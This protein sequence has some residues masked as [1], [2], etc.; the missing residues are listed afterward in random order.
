M[1][2][3]RPGAAQLISQIIANPETQL[4]ATDRYFR[5]L[6]YHAPEARTA[7]LRH[8]ITKLDGTSSGALP[9]SAREDAIIVR[10]VERID[11]FDLDADPVASAAVRRQLKRTHGTVA[12]FDLVKRFRPAGIQQSLLELLASDVDDST[13]VEAV[14]M[15]AETEDGL[16]ILKREL[17]SDSARSA[18]GIARVLGLWGNRRAINMLSDTASVAERSFDVRKEA[19]VG[20]AC[21]RPGQLRLISLAKDGRLPADSQLLAGGLLGQS[22][23]ESIRNEA[24]KCLPSITQKDSKPLAPIDKLSSM[25]GSVDNGVAIFRGVGTCANC[26]IVN[27]F[28]K[29]VGPDL[30]E[31][32][33]KLSREAMYTSILAP[34]AGISHNYETYSLLTTGGQVFS[35]LLISETPDEVTIRTVDAIDR[36][37][38]QG[39]IEVL[40]KADK[41]IM[42][43]NLHHTMDQQGLVD[44]VEY[45]MTLTK[46]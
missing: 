32:G 41:S 11:E 10:A 20:L 18:S 30:S 15:L 38:K 5:S 16:T 26:H 44:V 46:A 28:G 9:D 19:I 40:K 45:L 36:K 13:K 24:A 17:A 34:S 23:D 12:Y 2:G 8:L 3:S 31:I 43:D 22:T 1:E 27:E 14:A 35:G 7:A 42:P 25:R 21:N 37:F 29:S 4:A 39:D 6:E 33:S